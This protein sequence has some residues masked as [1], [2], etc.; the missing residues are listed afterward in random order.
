LYGSDNIFDSWLSLCEDTMD[1]AE[2]EA[3]RRLTEQ[4]VGL[5]NTIAD[6]MIATVQEYDPKSCNHSKEDT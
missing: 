3:K 5:I 2:E 1:I 6:E 4:L